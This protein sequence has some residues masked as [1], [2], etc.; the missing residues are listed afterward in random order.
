RFLLQ[1]LTVCLRPK[2]SFLGRAHQHEL[3]T[4]G[5]GRGG[6]ATQE[7]PRSPQEELPAR[8][9]QHTVLK[10]MSRLRT[11]PS[12]AVF[13]HGHPH[14]LRFCASITPLIS[15]GGH[16]SR[17]LWPLQELDEFGNRS[18]RSGIRDNVIV[19]NRRLAEGYHR[20]S[21]G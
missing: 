3:M 8:E 15:L 4:T 19:D 20:C 10:Q 16:C 2:G 17:R 5:D 18:A 14:Q 9:P 13:F 11:D 7:K 6:T 12:I 1:C 21:R